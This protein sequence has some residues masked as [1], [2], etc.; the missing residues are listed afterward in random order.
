MPDDTDWYA[1]DYTSGT[2]AQYIPKFQSRGRASKAV[3]CSK[4]VTL[5]PCW[6]SSS[7]VASMLQPLRTSY[8]LQSLCSQQSG[9]TSS[10]HQHTEYLSVNGHLVCTGFLGF[11]LDGTS[12]KCKWFR[13]LMAKCVDVGCKFNTTILATGC[14]TSGDEQSVA[15]LPLRLSFSDDPI[16]CVTSDLLREAK[17]VLGSC[18]LS[19]LASIR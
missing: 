6:L 2:C 14:S 3:S 19:F 5:A 7:A 13:R 10:D 1:I 4:T 15:R 12:T 11:F 17:S 9:G 16:P 8:Q 18:H